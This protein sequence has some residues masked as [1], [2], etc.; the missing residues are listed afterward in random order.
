MKLL[1]FGKNKL[2]SVI[3]DPFGKTKIIS[4][5]VFYQQRLFNNDQWYAWGSVEFKNGNT[6][7]EQRFEGSNFNDVVVQI[8]A[9]LKNL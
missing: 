2:P 4:I 3:N 1:G 8:D 7:G 9:M 6:K 5:S